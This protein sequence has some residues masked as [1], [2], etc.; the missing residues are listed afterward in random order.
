MG[1][2]IAR[3][4]LDFRKFSKLKNTYTD[5]L[6]KEINPQT[7]RIHTH[8][9][10]T[11]TITGR[12]SSSAPNL[13]NIPIKSLE[14]QKIRE[15]FVSEKDH[16]LISADYSQI[17]LRVIAHVAKIENL[18]QAFKE[19]KDIH[20]I[21]A[22]QVFGIPEDQIDDA[23]RSKAKAINFG[24]IYGISAFGLARQ[25][26][27][28]RQDAAEYIRS[29]LIAYPGIDAYM[30]DTI[31][32]ARAQGFVQTFSGRKCFISQINNKN[33]II[34]NEA[35]RLAINAPIQG[36]AADI[37]KKAMIRLSKKFAEEKLRSK[38]ILQIHDELI[39]EAP[40]DEV[41][42]ATKILKK[43]MESAANLDVPLKV[44]VKVGLNWS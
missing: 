28:S 44:D 7:G 14:G 13:Q 6:P 41:E 8:F 21:T 22:S 10:T 40:K 29:Y 19:E 25:L 4:I 42:I 9:S 31:E 5:A 36:S 18:V 11:S 12:L 20:R 27:I 34:R 30:K 43:E 2:P 17:E 33:P 26:D 24:I 37:I 1:H 38:I 15:S 39:V 35:E 3:K 23:T 32:L 16:F